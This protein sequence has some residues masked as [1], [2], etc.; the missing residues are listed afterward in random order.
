MDRLH[1]FEFEDQAWFPDLIRDAGSSYLV[2]AARIARHPQALAPILARALDRSGEQRVIDLCS[3]GSGPLPAIVEVFEANGRPPPLVQLTDLYPNR[4]ALEAVD[5]QSDYIVSRLDPVDATRVPSDLA[6]LRTLFSG[7]HH[8]RPPAAKRILEA[9][10]RDRASIAI[11]EVVARHPAA[12]ASMFLVP[13][14]T[15]LM[16]PFLRPFR[17]GWL[18]W[19]YVVPVIPL[20][21]FWDGIVSCLRC[22]SH[23]EL[24]ALADEV[25]APDYEWEI[26]AVELPGAPFDGAYLIGTPRSAQ[27]PRAAALRSASGPRTQAKR[28]QPEDRREAGDVLGVSV[29]DAAEVRHQVDHPEVVERKTVQAFPP[30]RSEA[31]HRP[32]VGRRGQRCDQDE[33]ETSEDQGRRVDR[34]RSRRPLVRDDRTQVHRHDEGVAE[35]ERSAHAQQPTRRRTGKPAR[36]RGRRVD[37]YEEEERQSGEAAIEEQHAIERARLELRDA[38]QDADDA[39]CGKADRPARRAAARRGESAQ[40]IRRPRFEVGCAA[41]AGSSSRYRRGH[42]RRAAS[43]ACGQAV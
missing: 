11:F 7:F 5:A 23:E 17:W 27:G 12:I 2:L 13:F 21:I 16:L 25:E 36:E 10:V 42:P 35:P 39:E 4:R 15:L 6:G 8:F 32:I 9:T 33:T 24:R 29:R 41:H 19:T 20:F 43:F 40:G 26:G 3:G 31:P 34:V 22:Y 30:A 1:L 18:V 14:M 37:R 38:G 28:Q